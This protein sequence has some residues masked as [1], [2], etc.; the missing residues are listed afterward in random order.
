[1]TEATTPITSTLDSADDRRRAY[2]RAYYHRTK[3]RRRKLAQHHK[4]SPEAQIAARRRYYAKRNRIIHAAKAMPCADCGREFPPRAMDLH[5][6]DGAKEFGVGATRSI[7][8]VRLKAEIAKCV[9]LC[10]VCHRLRH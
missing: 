6:A 8:V 3:E 1:M 2:H 10:A 7:S 5:H 4:L 9:V